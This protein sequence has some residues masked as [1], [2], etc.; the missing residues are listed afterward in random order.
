MTEPH[1]LLETIL[2]VMAASAVGVALFRWLRLSPILGYLS[3]G[4]LLGPHALGWLPDSEHTR[5]LAE[6]G[7]VFLMFTIGLEFSLST[8]LAHRRLVLGAGGL[9]VALGTLVFGVAAWAAGLPPAGAFA[10]G[11]ALAMSSTAIVLKELEDRL[12]INAPY[13]RIAVG[14]LL[15]QDLAAIPFLVV[16]PA[17]AEQHA[18]LAPELGSA[19]LKALAV[20][21]VLVAAGRWLLR[22]LLHAVSATRSLEL[23][24]ITTLLLALSAAWL[25]EAMGLS[26]ALGAFMAGMVLGETEFRHQVETDVLPF[27][28][29]LLGLFFVTIGMQVDVTALPGQATV[30]AWLLP[31]LLAGK[32]LV[33]A[34]AAG[35]TE[36]NPLTRLRSAVA[37]AQ[38]GEFGLLLLSMALA[39][40]LVPDGP[41]QSLLTALIASMALAP[42]LIRLNEPLAAGLLRRPAGAARSEQA[43]Q[44]AAQAESTSGHVILCGFG[45][46]GQNV[47]RILDL[48][49]IPW[50]ALDLDIGQ[51]RGGLESGLQVAFGD[52]TRPALLN[53]AGLQRARAVV[54]TFRGHQQALR[55]VHQVRRLRED[56]PV[57][58]RCVDARYESDLAEAGAVVF[59]EGL[60]ASLNLAGQLLSMLG[61]P[62]Q[63]VEERLAS[64][65][66]ENYAPLRGPASLPED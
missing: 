17:L 15:F 16:V 13:G 26:P 39:L 41:G 64:M 44:I 66:A 47:A 6:F 65:R 27:K 14:I 45:R 37:L 50:F 43:E 52:A 4:A 29:L 33:N 20:F 10:V 62:R 1:S 9:Q 11:G 19:V 34:T 53:A 5:L 28:D 32:L 23:F 8:L 24:M 46:T 35:V 63:V 18:A 55:I 57:L 25:S 51:V 36:R 7:V 42:V 2:I 58:V 30:L 38:G 54:I 31:A 48:E 56:L 12:E 3:V 21:G 59:P 60:E 61:S 40:G 22:P 49:G